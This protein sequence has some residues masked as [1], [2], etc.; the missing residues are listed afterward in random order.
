MPLVKCEPTAFGISNTLVGA[1]SA[2]TNCN[3]KVVF[4]RLT[5]T[6]FGTVG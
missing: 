2:A 1:I 5:A 4:V 6:D 3:K